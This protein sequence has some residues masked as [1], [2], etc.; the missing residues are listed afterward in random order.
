MTEPFMYPGHTIKVYL[1]GNN[2]SVDGVVVRAL[3]TMNGM[4]L[5]V[6]NREGRDADCVRAQYA[7]WYL[8]NMLRDRGGPFETTD[9]RCCAH[10]KYVESIYR[11]GQWSGKQ[12]CMF[13]GKKETEHTCPLRSTRVNASFVIL[14]DWLSLEAAKNFV[15]HIIDCKIEDDTTVMERALSIAT[16]ATDEQGRAWL[17]AK[18]TPEGESDAEKATDTPEA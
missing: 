14:C 10:C 15:E 16:Q 3:H 7:A 13:T 17:L 4:I 12:Q 8:T 11:E 2:Y 6:E 9:V 18:V 1:E 5:H